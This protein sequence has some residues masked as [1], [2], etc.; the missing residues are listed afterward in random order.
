MT[1]PLGLILLSRAI[2]AVTKLENIVQAI[3]VLA[4]TMKTVILVTYT[5]VK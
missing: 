3:P 4:R 5:D 2:Q 1:K